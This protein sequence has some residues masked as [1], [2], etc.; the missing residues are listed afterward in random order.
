MKLTIEADTR[1][2]LLAKLEAEIERLK[3]LTDS[4]FF[5]IHQEITKPLETPTK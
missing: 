4:E 3:G 2:E 1:P 5:L